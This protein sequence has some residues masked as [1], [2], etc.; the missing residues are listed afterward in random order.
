MIAAEWGPPVG[1]VVVHWY[2]TVEADQPT[3]QISTLLVAESERRRGIGRVLVK[4]AA[5]AA[6][7]AGCGALEVLA[8]AGEAGLAAFCSASGFI[9]HGRRFTRP[10][11]KGHGTDRGDG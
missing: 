5:Q 7:T 3:A 11:R 6:R 8:E 2:P 1:L 4:A 9:E 10:L